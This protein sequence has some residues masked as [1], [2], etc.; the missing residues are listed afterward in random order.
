VFLLDNVIATPPL[1]AAA[2][3]W[4]NPA[5][6]TAIWEMVGLTSSLF[7]QDVKVVDKKKTEVNITKP[8]F[9]SLL[10]FILIIFKLF[11]D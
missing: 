2:S 11:N 10:F 1:I 3:N 5:I 6:L 9:K 4:L 7:L 8:V